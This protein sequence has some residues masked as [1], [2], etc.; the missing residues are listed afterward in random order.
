MSRMENNVSKSVMEIS[1]P[2]AA[3]KDN[4]LGRLRRITDNAEILK[5]IDSI[6]LS[7]EDLYDI[8]ESAAEERREKLIVYLI[9]HR[10]TAPYQVGNVKYVGLELGEFPRPVLALSIAEKN[11]S[12]K[13][14]GIVL[15][16]C[17]LL[18]ATKNKLSELELQ[19]FE[20][21]LKSRA[22][23]E[24]ERRRKDVEKEKEAKEEQA[25][26]TV[27]KSAQVGS[28]VHFGDF[29][30]LVLRKSGDNALLITKDCVDQ[31]AFH[32]DQSTNS[33]ARCSLRQYLN[34]EF[35][36]KHFSAKDRT[37]ILKTKLSDVGCEDT[38]FL[39]SVDEAGSLFASGK[40]RIA[41]YKDNGA[42][43]WWLR[44]PGYSSISPRP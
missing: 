28:I 29:D 4:K 41:N 33:W 40:A 25:Y 26:R 13:D 32:T 39:L 3:E 10:F 34:G 24:E 5:K 8:L 21:E 6:A 2:L 9:G 31:R 11:I 38:L 1:D 20:A 30:W 35:L 44:S 43:W 42:C 37:R 22:S 16:N 36:K 12:L 15:E 23:A 17:V 7:Q 14:K 18:A 27:M 19:E